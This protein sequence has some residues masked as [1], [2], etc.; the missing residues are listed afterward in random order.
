VLQENE[1]KTTLS[2][3]FQNPIDKSKK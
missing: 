1:I 3:Q 2:D